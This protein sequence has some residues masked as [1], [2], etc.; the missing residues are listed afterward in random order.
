MGRT[1][2]KTI[3]FDRRGGVLLYD[4][5]R[6]K[7]VQ[8]VRISQGDQA[9]FVVLEFADRTELAISLNSVPTVVVSLSAPNSADGE[10]L[11]PIAESGRTFLPNLSSVKWHEIEQP[12]TER[13]P[14]KR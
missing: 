12:P 14:R 13:K 1:R 10:D 7:T 11:E 2:I 8:G 6:G 9:I 4:G 5:A 3:Q